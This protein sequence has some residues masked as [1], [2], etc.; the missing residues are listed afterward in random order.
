M[1]P[2]DVS[3]VLDALGPALQ[4]AAK[5]VLRHAWGPDGMPWGTTLDEL[6]G[7]AAQVGDRL[8]CEVL[9]TALE[10]QAQAELPGDL[11]A[12]PC[13]GG[14]AE[15]RPAKTRPPLHTSRGD[16]SWEQPQAYCPR[17]RRAFSPSGQEP[18]P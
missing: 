9:R 16:I 11:R 14:T 12:C 18:G 6:E 17:C 13:C 8:S 5:N 1:G 15:G 2:A 3:K 4:A 10:R 7:L